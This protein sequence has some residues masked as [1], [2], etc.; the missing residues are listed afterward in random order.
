VDFFPSGVL[1]LLHLLLP[2]CGLRGF[3]HR[4][5]LLV[6]NRELLFV[7][8]AERG[9]QNAFIRAPRVPTLSRRRRGENAHFHCCASHFSF[10]YSVSLSLPN[11][12]LH[13]DPR[14]VRQQSFQQ[15]QK[16]LFKLCSAHV[17]TLF[18][19]SAKDTF[20][21]MSRLLHFALKTLSG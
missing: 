6:R 1:L 8:D 9:P 3:I 18:S 20:S 16:E 7:C 15:Q 17:R 12:F 13:P 14:C 21:Q 19:V 5:A 10:H 11:L 2:G 4:N